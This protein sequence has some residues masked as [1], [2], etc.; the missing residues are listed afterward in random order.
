MRQARQNFAV[1]ADEIQLAEQSTE[2]TRVI[3]SMVSEL[4]EETRRIPS[5]PWKTPDRP[6]R[7][8]MV[9]VRDTEV[10]YRDIAE[11]VEGSLKLIEALSAGSRQMSGTRTASWKS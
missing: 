3:D 2:S 1:V 6:L 5:E 9:S 10:K 11:A 4:Q 7:R 8:D